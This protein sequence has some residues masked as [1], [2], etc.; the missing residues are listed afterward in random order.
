M[1]GIN[2]PLYK[3]DRIS[4]IKLWTVSAWEGTKTAKLKRPPH[5]KHGQ[6]PAALN[7]H[8]HMHAG[9]LMPDVQNIQ[10]AKLHKSLSISITNLSLIVKRKCYQFLNLKIHCIKYQNRYGKLI[11]VITISWLLFPFVIK[12]ICRIFDD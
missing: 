7:F 2:L 9:C 3:K 11:S 12:Y 1:R 5:H 4:E 10:F 6:P 8:E